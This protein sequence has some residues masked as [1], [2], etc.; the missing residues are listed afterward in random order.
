MPVSRG[1]D[2]DHPN[3]ESLRRKGF[4][5]WSDLPRETAVR[6]GLSAACRDDYAALV[7]VRDFFAA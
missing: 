3:A 6:P 4:S 7:P 2:R 1:F 5:V